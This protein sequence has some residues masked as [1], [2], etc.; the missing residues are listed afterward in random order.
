MTSSTLRAKDASCEALSGMTGIHRST[1][2][3]PYTVTAKAA[4]MN[5]RSAT[6]CPVS[7]GLR[8]SFFAWYI[9]GVSVVGQ[10]RHHPL[11]S[12]TRSQIFYWNPCKRSLTVSS[13]QLLCGIIVGLKHFSCSTAEWTVTGVMMSSV[14]LSLRL[15]VCRSVCDAVHALWLNA[16][17]YNKSKCTTPRGP[18]S[19]TLDYVNAYEGPWSGLI[20]NNTIGGLLDPY[21]GIHIFSALFLL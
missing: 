14:C 17:S 21:Q 6:D 7:V 11:F 4:A 12:G 16:T 13:G 2:H 3:R 1:Q 15:S 5:T 10:G 9:V 19:T 8:A 20:Q 18:W